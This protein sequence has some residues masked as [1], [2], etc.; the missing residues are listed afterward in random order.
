M[1]RPA[2]ELE[3]ALHEALVQHARASGQSVEAALHEAVARF[4]A[5]SKVRPSFRAASE[6]VLEEH[7]DLLARL[8]R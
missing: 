3:P 5:T 1:E 8:A 4:L 7:A 2:V 6:A